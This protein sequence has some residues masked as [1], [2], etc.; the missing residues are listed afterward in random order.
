VNTFRH[1][2][3][4]K[5]QLQ[6]LNHPRPRAAQP[7]RDPGHA[8]PGLLLGALTHVRRRRARRPARPRPPRNR[9]DNKLS[10]K[11]Q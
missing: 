5:H 1:P 11:N 3:Q 7:P 10:I 9:I 2:L 4:K 8:P 6:R